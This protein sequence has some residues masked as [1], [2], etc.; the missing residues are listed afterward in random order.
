MKK[1]SPSFWISIGR[2]L[3]KKCPRCGIGPLFSGFS[4]LKRSCAEC[5]LKYEQH[6]GDTWAFMYITTAMITGLFLIVLLWIW[7]PRS[8]IGRSLLGLAAFSAFVVTWPPRKGV[9]VAFEF[10]LSCRM[11]PPENLPPSPRDGKR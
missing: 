11:E 8:W 6:E 5:H 9:A 10:W 2:G 3:R 4:D 1:P 7:P